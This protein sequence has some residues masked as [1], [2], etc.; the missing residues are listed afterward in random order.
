MNVICARCKIEFYTKHAM[1]KYCLDCR[2]LSMNDRK[3]EAQAR[4]YA[5][6]KELRKTL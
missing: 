6:I 3:R 2:P 4:K 1:S 5:K